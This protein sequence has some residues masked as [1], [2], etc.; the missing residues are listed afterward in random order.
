[1]HKDAIMRAIP[2]EQCCTC[3]SMK[4]KP[5]SQNYQQVSFQSRYFDKPSGFPY[6]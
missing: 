4:S 6:K 5:Q 1:M 3:G 2:V